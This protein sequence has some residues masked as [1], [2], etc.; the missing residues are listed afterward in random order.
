M[1]EGMQAAR[2]LGKRWMLAGLVLTLV[3]Q[4]SVLAAE[5]LS[6][7]WPLTYGQPV[8]LKTEPIDPR[9]LF[10]GNYVRLNYTISQLDKALAEAPFR[11]HE[12]VYVVLRPEGDYHVATALRREPPA[13]GPFIRGR[14]RWDRGERYRIEYGIEAFFMPRQKALAAEAAVRSKEAAAQVYLLDNGRAAIAVLI[15]EGGCG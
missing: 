15:C 5:Y 11:Q 3:L 8:L 14:I 13:Q 2:P 9:S 4:L 12:V 6:S 10:R 1:A 7:V